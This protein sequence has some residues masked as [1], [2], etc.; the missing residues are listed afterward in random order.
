MPGIAGANVVQLKKRVK[1]FNPQYVDQWDAW[2]KT[3]PKERPAQL[4]WTLGKWQACRP[5][6]LRD[7]KYIEQLLHQAKP[8][9]QALR[10]FDI[11][12]PRIL[13][14]QIPQCHSGS[15]VDLREIVVCSTEKAWWKAA[16][17]WRPRRS[18]W[19]IEGGYARERWAYRTGV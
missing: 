3:E 13:Y 17:S 16:P 2:V 4:K 12:P 7:E 9:V 1:R 19:N 11:A 8:H 15:L 14:R 5:N 18:R 6:R 10:A